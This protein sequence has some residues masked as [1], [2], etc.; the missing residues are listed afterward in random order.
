MTVRWLPYVFWNAV[1]RTMNP[2]FQISL[3]GCSLHIHILCILGLDKALP[4]VDMLFIRP[5]LLLGF[6]IH[7]LQ[8]PETDD[9]EKPYK[10]FTLLGVWYHV[11]VLVCEGCNNKIP[12]TGW[13]N[14]SSLFPHKSGDQGVSRIGFF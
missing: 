11:G 2:R 14:N 10:P 3:R 12:Q 7:S 5:R 4:L 13:L 8:Y 6:S 9:E 1:L